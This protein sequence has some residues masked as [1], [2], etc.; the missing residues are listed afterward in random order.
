M[1]IHKD[2]NNLPPFHKAV[3]TIGT[4]DGVHTGH[5]Q[6]FQQL[7]EEASNINGESVVIT[8][9]PH[10]RL[11]LASS[12]HDLKLLNTLDE[13]LELLFHQYI[14]HIVVVPFTQEFSEQSAEE[15][16]RNFIVRYFHPQIIIIGYDHHF[17]KGRKGNYL[18]LEEYA[19]EYNYHVKEIP[20]HIL[21]EV[22]ISS[23]RIRNALLGNDIETA[24]KFL[25]YYYFFE[26]V[27]I[28]GDKIG[29]TLGY[30]TANISLID[31]NK[32]I[33][34]NG[35]YVV[36]IEV[37]SSGIHSRELGMMSIGVRPTLAKTARTIEV[38]IF[39][40]N[41]DIYGKTIRVILKHFLRPELKF[42]NLDELKKAIQGD[43]II[44]RE[45]LKSVPG[46]N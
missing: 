23:T 40:W 41:K 10:P 46:S 27:V 13:K 4:F 24:N 19:N 34:G 44:S 1:Q 25:G 7:K 22:I 3:I 37:C 5:R 15:Y 26:G 21:N 42:S 20:E 11:I 18:L 35:I 8:F 14:D 32:L 17:G 39:D 2:I 45:L 38:H 29:R 16:I 6:I 43:E 30:P 31:H 36:E 12:S 33:P 9:D 28:E